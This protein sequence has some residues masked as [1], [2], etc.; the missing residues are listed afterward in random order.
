MFGIYYNRKPNEIARANIKTGQVDML[1]RF[2]GFTDCTFGD[3]EGNLSNDDAS[4]LL[5][6][7]N[8]SSGAKTL[9][10]YDIAND[11]ILGEL[12]AASNFNWGSFSQRGEYIVVENNTYPDPAPQII[13][14]DR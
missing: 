8:E 9:I 2:D 6:R 4:V 12:V 13:R 5:A 10:S 14:Y 1:R 3:W 11:V 7:Q